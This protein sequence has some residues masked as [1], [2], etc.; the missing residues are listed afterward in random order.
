MF[1]KLHLQEERA[2]NLSKICEFCQLA[3]PLSV[4][5][6]DDLTKGRFSGVEKRH[7]NL[8]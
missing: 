5:N 8:K 6:F 1:I 4:E 2:I 7:A 3:L